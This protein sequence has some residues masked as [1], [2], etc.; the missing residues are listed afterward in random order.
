MKKFLSCLIFFVFSLLNAQI[1]LTAT[2]GTLTG[3]YST[4]AAVFT[5]INAGTHQG[6]ITIHINSS[7]TETVTS[8][9]NASGSGSAIYN[10][11]LI[12]PTAANIIIGGNFA[13]LITFNGADN[14]TI[15]GRVNA[16]GT[17]KSLTIITTS[18]TG[19]TLTFIND[20]TN[21]TIKYCN[22]KGSNTSAA[23]TNT[24][25]I[26]FSTASI[27]GN[28]NNTITKNNL[29]NAGIVPRSLIYS[30]GSSSC[31]N[32]GV[33]ISDNN[34][35]DFFDGIQTCY[36]LFV[37]SNS[38]DFTITG[39]SFYMQSELV[40]TVG[41]SDAMLYVNSSTGN[42]FVINDNYFGGSQPNCGG[43]FIKSG[44]YSNG[45]NALYIV[46]GTTTPSSIQGNVIK[47]IAWSNGTAGTLF[48]PIY[49]N[50]GSVNIGTERGNIIGSDVGTGAITYTSNGGYFYGIRANGAGVYNIKNNIIGSVTTLTTVGTAKN[51]LIGIYYGGSNQILI[52]SNTIGS[53]TEANSLNASSTSTDVAQIVR[54]IY[55]TSTATVSNNIISNLTNGAANTGVT[56][57]GLTNGIYSGNGTITI[58][59]NKINNLKIAN[60]NTASNYTASVTGIS[61]YNTLNTTKIQDNTI[62]NLSNTYSSF[63]G[64]IYGIYFRGGTSNIY[65]NFINRLSSSA[66]S[67]SPKISGLYLYSGISS[68]YNNIIS[69][70]G[71]LTGGNLY[72]I[73]EFNGVN[74]MIFNTVSIG[75][76]PTLGSDTSAA[77]YSVGSG[78]RK[79]IN[80]ILS[81][82]RSNNGSSGVNYSA[83]VDS[84]TNLEIDYNDYYSFGTGNILGHFATDVTTLDELKTATGQDLSSKSVNPE[85]VNPVGNATTDYFP[86]NVTLNGTP[87]VAIDVDFNGDDRHNVHPTI[88]AFENPATLPVELISFVAYIINGKVS[89]EWS[90]A[91]EV[92]NYGFE[93]ERKNE[94]G[95]WSKLSFIT[96]NGNSNTTHN[97]FYTDENPV[98]GTVLYRLKQ[99]DNDGGFKYS[100]IVTVNNNLVE[101]FKLEQNYPNPFNP[102]T[103]IK[104]SLPKAVFVTIKVY[105]ILGKEVSVLLNENKLAGNYSI[106]FDAANLSSGTYIYVITAGNFSSSK[107]MLLLK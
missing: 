90:T 74:S 32:S 39:N 101:D 4:L 93:I 34:L 40:T 20:A 67:T 7:T 11:I 102:K 38:T 92:Q 3:N 76:S 53:L 9:L 87:I 81:N 42:N 65:N 99:I 44:A 83:Y 6:D 86:A 58:K 18:S 46:C 1:S 71:N 85:F 30:Y 64:N 107:K 29:T 91:T 96:G 21:N 105:N 78:N 79:V 26:I 98:Q 59:N 25:M 106:D 43:T 89:L 17:E 13:S 75:G 10:S 23:S 35:Y 12:Y 49:C 97:Y 69:L 2:S 52:D 15:D 68:V 84:L 70:A 63:I 95:S 41:F 24:G 55:V 33:I 82:T 66:E 28:D 14:V 77:I 45:F 50:G 8:S 47:N 56:I 94:N 37:S 51:D 31:P 16:A 103:V 22:I 5:A 48:Y 62:S 88:G 61:V 100:E 104:Y 19:P 27:T 54:G 36:P 57:Y 73:Y 80:N 60:A 72:G